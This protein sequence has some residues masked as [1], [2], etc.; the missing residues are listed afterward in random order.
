MKHSF[1]Y[2]CLILAV[3][4]YSC[5]KENENN[6]T[7]TPQAPTNN[8]EEN[9]GGGNGNNNEP[10]T[11][12]DGELWFNGFA[13]EVYPEFITNEWPSI[14]HL[15]NSLNGGQMWQYATNYV[16][17]TNSDVHI[18]LMIWLNGEPPVGT[19]TYQLRSSVWTINA[20]TS[21]DDYAALAVV[22]QAGGYPYQGL[23][24][25][26]EMLGGGTVTVT[27]DES[28]NISYTFSDVKVYNYGDSLT[29]TVTNITCP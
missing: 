19:K 7:P 24:H 26:N 25:T 9:N 18:R 28:N 17:K 2:L 16:R 11:V 8:V 27:R 5:G 23:W 13:F 14:C 15:V 22:G 10:E 20:A 1:I 12:G 21:P 29:V 3:C 4:F 6:D